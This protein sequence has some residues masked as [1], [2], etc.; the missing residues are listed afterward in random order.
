M[1]NTLK[2]I[3]GCLIT[4][5]LIFVM[6]NYLGYRLDPEYSE[7]GFDAIEAFHSLE[8]DSVEVMIFGSSH[9]WKGCDAKL[10]YEKYGIN[11]YNYACNWQAINTSTL[12]VRDALR[13]QTPKVVCIETGK[14]GAIFNN[15][16]MDGQVY[17]TRGMDFFPGKWEYLYQCLGRRPDRWLS[18]FF[19]IFMFHDNWSHVYV[20]NWID[21]GSERFVQ[22]RGY[23]AINNIFPCEIP[24]Y[25]QDTQ[26]S[27]GESGIAE[28][29]K[30]IEACRE[31]NVEVI[32]YTCPYAGDYPYSDSLK[33]FAEKYDCT[34]I[35]LFEHLD[36]M[37]F[38]G[39][40]DM[41]DGE[42]VNASGAAKVASYLSEYILENYEL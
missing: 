32:L 30:M 2:N 24:D 1:K 38:D 17:Y 28:L 39:Q 10:M 4:V 15:A 22:S 37:E 27:V 31:K 6:L 34:Y 29:E 14:V 21:Q 42:H 18:Y 36:E 3:A 8:D 5:G 23:F 26:E 19:P 9:A 41:N 25:S 35:N 11:A 16:N 33:E 40:T 12:F 7:D 20:E 13:T